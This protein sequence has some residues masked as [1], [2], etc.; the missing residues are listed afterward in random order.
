MKNAFE[1]AEEIRNADVYDP[2]LCRALCVAAG[3]ESEW[4][5]A[6]GENFEAVL[7][8]AAQKLGVEI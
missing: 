2:D 1:I 4:N 5:A 6:D 8:A 7:A 3:M